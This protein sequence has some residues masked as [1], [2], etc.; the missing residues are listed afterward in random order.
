MKITY[1]GHAAF[2]V[3]TEHALIFTDLWL[4]PTGAF[5]SSW[6]QLPRNHHLSAFVQEQ[7]GRSDKAKFVYISHE[8][9]D[10][11]DRAFLD[12][13][14][15]REF[16]LI[17]PRYRRPSFRK[18]I[19]DYRC[20]E[21]AV[22]PDGEAFPIPGGELKL[23]LD[24]SEL[25]RDS[26][27]FVRADGQTFLN[28]NDCRVFDRLRKI[29]EA[30]GAID[31]FTCQFSGASW[32]PT[33]YEYTA[34]EFARISDAKVL[35]KFKM[36]DRAI[37]VVRPRYF[38]PS[39][40]PVCF[41]D[42][43]LL[44]INFMS[45]IFRR[46]PELLGYIEPTLRRTGTQWRELMPGDVF[47]IASGEVDYAP[48]E[49]YDDAK[50]AS[51]LRMYANQY[52][53]FFEARK[54]VHDKVDADDVLN[55]LETELR[56][57]LDLLVLRDRVRVPLYYG[58]RE[59]PNAWLRIDF[60]GKRVERVDGEIAE[61]EYYRIV[62]FAWQLQDVLDRK[63]TWEN[64]GLTFRVRLKRIPD[65][66][67]ALIHA[68]LTL[69]KGDLYAFCR[70]LLDLEA[71]KERIEIV[72]GGKTYAVNRYCPHNGGDLR[73]GW[74]EEDRYLVCARHRWCFDLWNGG[75]CTTNTSSIAAEEVAGAA[76]A[77]E[78]VAVGGAEV[79]AVEEPAPT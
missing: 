20:K 25:N 48:G 24:D 42:P 76:A 58:V 36:V 32:H 26:A 14:T 43:E 73:E 78:N 60:P 68:Y 40:G 59:R 71:K 7:L 54:E 22:V 45:G 23:F 37:Q 41:L 56:S 55:R 1:L 66:Y 11:Y 8:H 19:S 16:T 61:A 33:C 38:L 21:I 4:S 77:A 29:S 6:F 18:A 47:D 57:K 39:A 9:E 13:L 50:F 2:A 5:D 79:A 49:R 52:T 51:Y 28:L 27:L 10:H 63:L 74:I 30:E 35:Q 72:A 53:G 64:F 69:D 12:S 67:E 62:A 46:A 31:V 70:M 44:E 15:H 75:A 34:E 17:I 65:S 3:E